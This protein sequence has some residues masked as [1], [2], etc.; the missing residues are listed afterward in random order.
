[1]VLLFNND[2][3]KYGFPAGNVTGIVEVKHVRESL[4]LAQILMPGLNNLP[5]R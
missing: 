3:D 2:A 4:S 5:M 1:M